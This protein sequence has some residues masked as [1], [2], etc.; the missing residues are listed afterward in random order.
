[1]LE[2]KQAYIAEISEGV[3]TLSFKRPDAG[4]AIPQAAVESLTA[5]FRSVSANTAVRA[6]CVRG[7]GKHFCTGGDVRA[8]S[9]ILEL[10]TAERRAD[11]KGRLDRVN[12]LVLAYSELE[13]P[14]VARS[15]EQTSELQS[16]MR[17]SY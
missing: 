11:F 9:E 7:E 6:V 4:N 3:L 15:E 2:G 5:L 10:G 16:L 17:I 14:V 1:M 8:F 12:A 13:V